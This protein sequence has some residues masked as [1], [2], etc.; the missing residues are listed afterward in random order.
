VLGVFGCNL[1][2]RPNTPDLI[3]GMGVGIS[4]NVQVS[5]SVQSGWCASS[6]WQSRIICT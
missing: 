1:K 4:A 5:K 6:T 3:S 2:L